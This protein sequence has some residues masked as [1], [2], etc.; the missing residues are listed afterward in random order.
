MYDSW[1]S[2]NQRPLSPCIEET[3]IA[4]DEEV[5]W[6]DEQK[7]TFRDESKAAD[8]DASSGQRAPWAKVKNKIHRQS[9]DGAEQLLKLFN[10][11]SD[12]LRRRISLDGEAGNEEGRELERLR[13]EVEREGGA[14]RSLSVQVIDLK[15]ANDGGDIL[16]RLGLSYEDMAKAVDRM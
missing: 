3:T 5:G 13:D 14:T 1:H 4:E 16:A 9:K 10:A 15:R 7:S 2:N 6:V 11:S 8:T 12:S